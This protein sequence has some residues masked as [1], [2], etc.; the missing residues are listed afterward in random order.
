MPKRK[1]VDKTY[2]DL[3]QDI[4]INALQENIKAFFA[5]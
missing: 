1:T 3:T 4:D 5:H 2:Q